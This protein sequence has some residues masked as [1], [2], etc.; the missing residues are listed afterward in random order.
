MSP[1]LVAETD[2]KENAG[3]KKKKK[4]QYKKINSNSRSSSFFYTVKRGKVRKFRFH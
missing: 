1:D 3:K 2:R 4:S